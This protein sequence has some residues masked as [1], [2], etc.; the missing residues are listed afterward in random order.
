MEKSKLR[1]NVCCF[2]LIQSQALSNIHQGSK[3][4]PVPRM[5]PASARADEGGVGLGDLQSLR[6][7]SEVERPERRLNLLNVEFPGANPD[8]P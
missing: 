3:R 2:S 7:L 6:Y 5:R 4:L 1:N 8:P